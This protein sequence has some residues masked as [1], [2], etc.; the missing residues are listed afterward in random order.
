M[1]Y[2]H[3]PTGRYP[4]SAKHIRAEN[5]DVSFP[6]IFTPPDDYVLVFSTNPPQYDE[7]TQEVR[8]LTPALGESGNWEQRWEVVERYQTQ[9]EKDA[10]I[11]AHV[12]SMK[13]AKNAEINAARLVANTSAFTHAGKSFACDAL[14]RSDIDGTNGFIAL[15]GVMPPGWPG[16]WKAVDNTYLPIS[17]VE[18]W[19]A[20]YTSMF[21]AGAAHFAKAQLLKSQLE[22]ATTTAE[23]NAINW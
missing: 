6:E 18:E 8:E 9:S 3:K 13:A 14:S 1:S 19:K 21:A 7:V 5:Q 22:Q 15:Y 10:A 20:F 16:G 12:A 23:I 17:T 2:L 11:Q 4:L